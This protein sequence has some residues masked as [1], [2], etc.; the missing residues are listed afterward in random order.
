MACEYMKAHG[1]RIVE[2]NY[3]ADHGIGE[4]DIVAE[5]GDMLVFCEVKARRDNR[6]GYAIEAVTPA[7]IKQIVTTAEWY[8][9]RKRITDRDIRFDVC[10]VNLTTHRVEYVPNAFTAADA[11]RRNHW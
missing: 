7:K 1:M 5:E 9:R 4:I 2:R 10:A 3:V 11:G 8:L 6:M